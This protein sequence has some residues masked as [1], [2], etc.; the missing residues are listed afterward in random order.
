MIKVSNVKITAYCNFLPVMVKCPYCYWKSEILVELP[1]TRLVEKGS[2]EGSCSQCG[3]CWT[4]D[5]Q[6]IEEV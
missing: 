4:F 2:G 6:R 1:I 3:T 5:W